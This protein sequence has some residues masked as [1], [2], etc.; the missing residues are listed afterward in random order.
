[1]EVWILKKEKER[2]SPLSMK[3]ISGL[4]R[5]LNTYAEHD[6]QC[7]VTLCSFFSHLACNFNPLNAELNTIC[8]SQLAELFCAVFKFCACFSKNLNISRTERDTFV[9]WKA[10]CGEGNRHWSE[11]LKNAISSLLLDGEDKFLNK[12]VN[13]HVFYLHCGHGF[14]CLHGRQMKI[15]HVIFCVAIRKTISVHTKGGKIWAWRL[16]NGRP[17]WRCAWLLFI[18]RIFRCIIF[19]LV[20]VR[21]HYG[22]SYFISKQHTKHCHVAFSTKLQHS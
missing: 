5:I 4:V 13:I 19:L 9:K 12:L 7:N 20:A 16:W 3:F 15:C 14:N 8:K 17:S 6:H 10:F 2:G 1:M 11:C 22:F 18:L 21:I